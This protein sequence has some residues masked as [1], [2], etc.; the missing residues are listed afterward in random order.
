MMDI[1]KLL[2]KQLDLTRQDQI[3][4][5]A[6]IKRHLKKHGFDREK[7]KGDLD[8]GFT[9]LSKKIVNNTLDLGIEWLLNGKA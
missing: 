7:L 2:E 5:Q 6:M 3:S 9:R 1:H 8:K 4:Y